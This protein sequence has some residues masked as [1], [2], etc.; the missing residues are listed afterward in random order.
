[1]E[2]KEGVHERRKRLWRREHNGCREQKKEDVKRN[3]GLES[4]EIVEER[5][6]RV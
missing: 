4:N 1:M 2:R 5:G 3:E 6:R